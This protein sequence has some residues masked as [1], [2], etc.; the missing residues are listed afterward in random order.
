MDSKIEPII[1]DGLNYAIWETNMEMLLK[2][3]GLWQYMKVVIPNLFDAGAKFV[4][5]RKKDEVVG[6]IMT[7]ISYKIWYHTSGI[8]FPYVV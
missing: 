4:V 5:D 2:S 8:D 1:L 3:K 7:Y 6:V